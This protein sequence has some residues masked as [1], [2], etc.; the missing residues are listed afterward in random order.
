NPAERNSA[1]PEGKSP[2]HRKVEEEK[3][4]VEGEEDPTLALMRSMG[5]PTGFVGDKLAQ[6]GEEDQDDL[7][8]GDSIGQGTESDEP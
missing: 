4:A 1:Q 2:K 5:L 3:A 7:S 8:D 6:Y